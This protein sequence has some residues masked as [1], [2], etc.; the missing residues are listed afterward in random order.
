M[1]CWNVVPTHPH[2]PAQ[3]ASNRRPSRAEVDASRVFLEE[4]ARNR[5]VI[6]VGRLAEQTIGA[7]GVRH[8]SHGGAQAFREGLRRFAA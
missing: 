2:R 7:Q 1:L 3:P 5:R 4:L 6:A 8:P